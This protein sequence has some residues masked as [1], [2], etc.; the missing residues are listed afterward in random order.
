MSRAGSQLTNVLQ[1]ELIKLGMLGQRCD[2]LELG[3]PLITRPSTLK[4]RVQKPQARKLSVGGYP[5]PRGL[6]GQDFFRKVNGKGGT[7]PPLNGQSVFGPIF[8]G[9]FLNGKGG[10]VPENLTEK[11]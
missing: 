8:N 5:P 9:F 1:L 11:S 2:L 7:P 4:G 3:K 6:H 10:S